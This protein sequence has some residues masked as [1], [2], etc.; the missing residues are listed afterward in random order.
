MVAFDI[1]DPLVTVT[2]VSP[3]FKKR[4]GLHINV[5]VPDPTLII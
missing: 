5:S 3:V 1:V 2:G 4:S